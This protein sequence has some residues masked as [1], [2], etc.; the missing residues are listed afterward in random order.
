MITRLA[1]GNT[2]QTLASDTL[3][4]FPQVVPFTTTVTDITTQTSGAA[5]VT[6]HTLPVSAEEVTKFA[7]ETVCQVSGLTAL[8]VSISVLTLEALAVLKYV[9]VAADRAVFVNVAG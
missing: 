7:F 9:P 4:Y 5:G 2:R 3:F 8:A 6:L 1:L